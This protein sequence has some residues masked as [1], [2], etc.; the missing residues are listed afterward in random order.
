MYG[1]ELYARVRRVCPAKQR[2]T[3]KR[4]FDRLHEECGFEGSSTIIEDYV[5]E[6]PRRLRR[7]RCPK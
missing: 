3:A 6:R 5:R 1:V 2:Y 4:I 7:A